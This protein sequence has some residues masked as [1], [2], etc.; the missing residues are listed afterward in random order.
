MSLAGLLVSARGL[1]CLGV[2]V[3][4]GWIASH[5]AHHSGPDVF[6][7]LFQHVMPAALVLDHEPLSIPLPGFLSIFTLDAAGHPTGR[8]A[9]TNLQVFQV[10]AVLLIG[11]CLAGVP[12]HLRAGG[13]DRLTRVFAGW[14]LWIRDEMVVPNLGKELGAR[15]LP[16]VLFVFF[17]VLFMNALGLVPFGATATASI[18]VTGAMALSTFLVMIFGGMAAQGPV[19]FWKHLVPEVPL[20]LWPLMFVVEVVGLLVKPFALMIRLFANM[21]GGHLIVLSCIGLIMFFGAEGARPALGYAS[22]PLAVGFAVFIMI[23]ETFV[24]LLQAYIFTTLS[25]LFIGASIHPQH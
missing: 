23:I 21:T 9:L 10:A 14:A 15:F 17:F 2:I 19:A 1:A 6:Q 12:R 25:I 22:A 4:A 20:L 8:L 13:G 3:L 16:Y 18:A 11:L 7:T 5:G 24:A